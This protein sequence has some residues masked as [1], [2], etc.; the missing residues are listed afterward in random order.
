MLVKMG[1]K[2]WTRG[3]QLGLRIY[4]NT[5]TKLEPLLDVPS[6]D[7]RWATLGDFIKAIKRGLKVNAYTRRILIVSRGKQALD[8]TMTIARHGRTTQGY[9]TA[10][11][12]TWFYNYIKENINKNYYFEFVSASKRDLIVIPKH[13]GNIQIESDKDEKMM[14]RKVVSYYHMQKRSLPEKANEIGLYYEIIE[15]EYLEKLGFRPYHRY[16]GLQSKNQ[17]LAKRNIS[18]D[19]D[20]FDRKNRF[21]KFVEVKSVSAAPGSEFNL[22]FNEYESRKKCIKKKWLYEIVIYYHVGSNIIERRVINIDDR[23]IVV[24]SG[25]I[26]YAEREK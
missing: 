8:A 18:C 21:I 19:I 17:R 12:R 4:T 16:P 14:H 3:T 5:I 25:Y 6:S 7:Q 9:I 23:L 13:K 20:V 2:K 26:C 15:T 11:H 24:P 1:C 10:P 22:T